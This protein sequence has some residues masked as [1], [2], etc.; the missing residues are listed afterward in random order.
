MAT[1]LTNGKMAETTD[2]LLLVERVG[3]LLHTTDDGHLL[4]PLKKVLLRDLDIEAGRVR[5][6]PAERVLMQ[7][8]R[9]GLRVGRV[10]VEL[11]SIGRCLDCPREVLS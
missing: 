4:V 7:L 11:G 3:R 2:E 10:L 6:V 1:H 8:D 9:E 5:P